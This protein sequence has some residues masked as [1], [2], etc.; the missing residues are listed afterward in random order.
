MMSIKHDCAGSWGNKKACSGVFFPP[1]IYMCVTEL[2]VVIYLN[3]T[4]VCEKGGSESRYMT[5]VTWESDFGSS[6][7]TSLGCSKKLPAWAIV[8]HLWNRD[9]FVCL[10]SALRPCDKVQYVITIQ[11]HFSCPILSHYL[12]HQW[13]STAAKLDHGHLKETYIFLS[14]LVEASQGSLTPR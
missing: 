1:H 4:K 5:T 2:F 3:R 11:C 13:V 14:V 10:Q 6:S 12:S 7:A 9:N 8:S